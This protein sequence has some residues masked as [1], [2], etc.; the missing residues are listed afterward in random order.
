M[1][2]TELL[3]HKFRDKAEEATVTSSYH[4]SGDLGS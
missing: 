2:D 3:P 4:Y 1:R